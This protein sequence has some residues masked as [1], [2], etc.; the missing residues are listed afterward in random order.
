M[1]G[2]YE[3]C[4]R[5]LADGEDVVMATIMSKS[6]STPQTA[7][8]KMLVRQDGSFVGTIGGG[9][10]E[11]RVLDLA[12]D[13]F[14]TRRSLIRDFKY[15]GND[16][17]SMGV[18]GGRMDV[19]VDFLSSRMPENVKIFNAVTQALP[20]GKRTLLV[21]AL[22]NDTQESAYLPRCLLFQG[23]ESVGD[24]FA[25]D[26]Q[27]RFV[28]GFKNRHP[29]LVS[30]DGVQ[31]LLEP[32][33]LWG[34]VYLFGAGHVAQ[35]VARL[36]SMVDFRTV[37]VDDRKEFATRERFPE[38]NEII[39]L[40]DF[41]HC[42]KDLTITSDSYLVIVTRGHK[43]DQMVLAQALHTNAGYIGMMGSN[44]KRIVIYQTLRE[45]GVTEEQLAHVYSP[46]GLLEDTDTPEE[47][48]ISIM[49][50]LIKVRGEKF[51][52]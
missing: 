7:G 32:V 19:L 37:V 29:Q 40:D 18:C 46:I 43:Y 1:Q 49:A 26:Q 15:V 47:I 4:A 35:Q 8:T 38:A 33:S 16:E 21:T 31:Y 51:G 20:S 6:G 13:V 23:G 42:M 36:T 3:T 27:A 17:N 41:E 9:L 45:A 10:L 14:K 22:P 28:Q 44:R 30:V 48:A 2:L 50:E 39:V 5:L 11:A 25:A 24:R 52:G 12:N 34:T